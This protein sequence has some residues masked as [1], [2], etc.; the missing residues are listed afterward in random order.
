[1]QQDPGKSLRPSIRPVRLAR[2][3]V[4]LSALALAASACISPD[5]PLV[6]ES[7]QG[8]D[9][10]QTGATI[11]SNLKVDRKVRVFMQAASDFAASA[12][13][14][15]AQVI[16][17]CSKV[18]L[19]LG[20][21]DSWS[22][23]DDPDARMSNA[24]RTGACDV[25]ANLIED[26][27]IEAGRVNAKVS[28]LVSKGECHL[29]FAEQ[30]KC[31]A[32]CE[33]NAKCDPGTVETRCEPGNLSVQCQ[34][35]CQAGAVC[36]GLPERPA[37]CMGECESTCVGQCHGTCTFKDGRRTE[38][39][40]NCNGKCSASCNGTCR[41]RCKLEAPE[42]VSCGASVRC[43]G[44]CSA[45]FSDP[46]CTTE[47]TPPKCTVDPDCHAACSARVAA[48]A[49][50]DPT[51]VEVFADIRATPRLRPLIDTL[52]ANLPALIEAAEKE[53]QQAMNAA[54]RLGEVGE[55][56]SH[57]IEDLDGKSL[58]CLGKA[59][60]AVGEAVSSFDVSVQASV[61]VTVK[62]HDAR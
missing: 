13:R 1:M 11:D 52:Q 14:I 36:V 20:A 54:H 58:A 38:N 35:N 23:I 25:A 50:C 26:V 62:T 21:E 29:D 43:T 57:R 7:S 41:G 42:G 16:D 12:D 10:F 33:A 27:L 9:E 49:V 6:E 39:D 46:V 3:A 15:Q 40:A 18:A 17:A 34:A 4:S 45:S 30:A 44:G 5:S 22:S 61:D 60:S 28:V 51:Q 37:N 19:D 31:D 2:V 24:N 59:S 48:H 55:K 47:F 56:L 53:G 32:E 8:C